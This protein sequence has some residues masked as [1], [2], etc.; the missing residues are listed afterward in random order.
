MRDRGRILKE[1]AQWMTKGISW[2]GGNAGQRGKKAI[3][4]RAAVPTETGRLSGRKNR[5]KVIG[6]EEKA[7]CLGEFKRMLP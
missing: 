3:L 2:R 1:N 4:R 6:K 5:G 7:V